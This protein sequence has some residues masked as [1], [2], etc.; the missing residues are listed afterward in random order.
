MKIRIEPDDFGDNLGVGFD[1]G[2]VRGDWPPSEEVMRLLAE[3]AIEASC[4]GQSDSTA[5]NDSC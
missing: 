4:E 1:T 2:D 5:N 3:M